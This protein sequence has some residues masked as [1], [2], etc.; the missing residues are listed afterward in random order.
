MAM[1]SRLEPALHSPEEYLSLERAAEFKSEY[2]NGEI[3]AMSGGSPEHSAISVN[4]TI[5]IG[6]QLRGKPCRPFSNDMKVR[7]DPS[8]LF[9]YPDLSVVCGEPLHHDPHR[10]ILTHPTV[11]VEVLSPSTEAFDRGRKFAQYQ[12]IET[13]SDYILIAQDE[14]RVEHLMRRPGGQWLLT[15]IAGLPGLL[16]IES[17]DC[18]LDLAELYDRISF[19]TGH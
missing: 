8:G 11:I 7:T 10:D 14:P 16:Y 13:L 4:V 1:Q 12:R 3:F 15:P 5:S 19:L 18:T 17:I 6:T 2:L 9:S